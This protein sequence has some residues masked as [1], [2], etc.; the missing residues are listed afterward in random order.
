MKTALIG[1][2]IFLLAGILFGE[3]VMDQARKLAQQNKVDEAV[4]LLRNHGKT[5]PNDIE[6]H[7]LIQT[8][9]T[10]HGRKEEALKEYKE[11]YEKEPTGL[12]GY[13]YVRL[14]DV[15]SE[16]EKIFREVAGKD[17]NSE[18]GYYG[19]ATAL[20]DQDKLQEG[21]DQA[22]AGLGKAQKPAQIH[23]VMGRIYRRMK[24]YKNAAEQMR[25]YHQLE[26]TDDHREDEWIEASNA[27]TRQ[28]KLDLAKAWWQKY[29]ADYRKP[30]TLEDA[31]RLA[32]I[33][34]LYADPG[35]DPATVQ[36]LVS[37]AL[38]IVKKE[39]LPPAG[40]DRDLYLRIKGAL[41]AL[42]GWAGANNKKTG[43]A[44][45]S[46]QEGLKIGPSSEMFYFTALAKQTIGE[47]EEALK[48]ALKAAC[49]P[50][51]YPGS[52]EL[53]SNLWKELRSSEDGLEAALH[54]QREEFTPQRKQRVLSQM[55][56]E[57][58]EPFEMTGT[59]EKKVTE[60][61]LSGK[62]V[63]MNFWAVWCPPC[64]E[65]LPH[66]NEFY[67]KHKNDSDLM[68]VTVG[69]E[70]WETILN[71]MRNQNYSFSVYRNEKYWEQF[72][73]EGIPTMV[74]LDPEGTIRFRNV[75]FEEGM[76]YE[77]TLEWQI[78]AVRSGSNHGGTEARRK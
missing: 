12:N 75:G 73:V 8:I 13:L 26:P 63:L 46:L 45:K 21:I 54:Q 72:S 18:W 7:K 58:F 70:P 51:V 36:A 53:A 43:Q 27:A 11:R 77:E 74:I 9:L 38:K 47:K 22:S 33:S 29:K 25:L 67:A 37:P 40:E 16:Q 14:F 41:F 49:Y 5:H 78:D 59:Q 62:I 31:I 76:E 50:P 55:V 3:D 34:F 66:W 60:K 23:Y 10:R 42:K 39:K 32:E 28:E 1:V 19:L 48:N 64:R 71:Y 44:Q 56:T 6:L 30:E 65:E 24:D 61:D 15:P 20:L 17:P 52:K 68:L 69:D 4:A 35:N 57:K 2:L